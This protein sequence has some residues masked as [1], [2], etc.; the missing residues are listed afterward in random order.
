MASST[1]L[2]S[3]ELFWGHPVEERLP[4][5]QYRP[6][7][8]PGLGVVEAVLRLDGV[9]WLVPGAVEVGPVLGDTLEVLHRQRR[10]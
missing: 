7:P 4:D 5:S 9:V 8:P 1:F 2:V 6:E 10:V 3:W